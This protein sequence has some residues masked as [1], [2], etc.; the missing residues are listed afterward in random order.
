MVKLHQQSSAV[1]Q[2][3]YAYLNTSTNQNKPAC[4][5]QQSSLNSTVSLQVWLW[6]TK[7]DNFS[8]ST[9]TILLHTHLDY[10]YHI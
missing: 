4:F 10:L 2:Y 8:T 1:K 9:E 7:T 6:E 3:D 5:G